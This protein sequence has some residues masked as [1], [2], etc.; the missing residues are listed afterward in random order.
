MA[1]SLFTTHLLREVNIIQTTRLL[2]AILAPYHDPARIAGHVWANH[3]LPRI[4]GTLDTAQIH[5]H[6]WWK[7]I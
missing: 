4:V 1:P 2:L 7:C 3:I 6:L 5:G